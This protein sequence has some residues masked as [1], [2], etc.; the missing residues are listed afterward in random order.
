MDFGV[1]KMKKDV[2][3]SE[4]DKAAG[5]EQGD[6]RGQ[7]QGFTDIVGNEHDGFA[8]TAG[9]RTEF[10]LKLGAGDGVER[11]KRLVHEENGGIGG[12]GAGNADALALAAGEFARVACC[13]FA[14][15]ET[16]EMHHLFKTR[17]P[18][19]GR[20]IFEVGNKRDVFCNREMGE[21]AS[22]L[23]DIADAAAKTNG[24]PL[25]G[26]P[27]VDEHCS[28]GG[29]QESIDE[30]EERG[31]AAA[32]AAEEDESFGRGDGKRNIGDEGARGGAVCGGGAAGDTPKL[33]DRVA[34]GCGFRIHFG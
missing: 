33:D 34:G 16:Y 12:E 30:L 11:A 7:E 18:F 3:R 8:E 17:E 10:T 31:L 15:T 23:N 9:E 19:G 25:G 20:P 24:I 32:A 28:R 1:R 14:E 4:G 13:E 26:G 29:K 27:A 6:A 22:F 2:G 21:K 5:L